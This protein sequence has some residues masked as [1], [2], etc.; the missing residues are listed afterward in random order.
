MP[1]YDNMIPRYD[2]RTMLDKVTYQEPKPSMFRNTF[3]G[4][5]E[6][7]F[8][9][10][11]A[12][13]DEVREGASMARY[14]GDKLEVEATETEP[15]ITR[16]IETPR[17]QEK[18]VLDL[19]QFMKRSAGENI[20]SQRTPADRAK[21]EENKALAF[22][23]DAVDRRIEQ[24]CAQ[25]MVGGRIDIVGKGVDAY[26]DYDLP[27]RLTLSGGSQWGQSGVKPF[28]NLTEWATALRKRNYNP[29]MILMDL[30]V[31]Q[32]FLDDADYKAML[33]NRRMEMGQI[34]PG[35]ML[36]IFETAQYF[37]RFQWPGL[38]VLDAYTY[39]GTYKNDQNVE[40]PY[41]DHGRLLMLTPEA[42]QNR[43]LYGA[44]TIVD[45]N[46]DEVITVEGRYVPEVFTDRRAKTRTFM[47]T[48]RAMPA[49]FQADSWY[50]VK[51]FS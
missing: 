46:T 33:D 40:T 43:I 41:L 16:E 47:V 39:S 34:A 22:C 18:R 44:E 3:F 25:L 7:Y 10:K 48:S 11:K 6:V 30:S 36:D 35:E 49:P 23:M 2:T 26:V 5:E 32:L 19:T 12:E 17:F 42:R 51:V 13:W 24:Q 28:D 50:S 45:E 27:L 31:A 38:G 1:A 8:P 14:V 21:E 9:T 4:G 29:D 20:Y 37:A 15:F